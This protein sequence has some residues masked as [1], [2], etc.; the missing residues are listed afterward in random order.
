LDVASLSLRH[1]VLFASLLCL[2][3]G[4]YYE[5]FT[6]EQVA[7]QSASLPFFIGEGRQLEAVLNA[8]LGSYLSLHL[9][10]LNS[11]IQY[12]AVFFE[13]EFDYKLP[14]TD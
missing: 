3:A 6:Q 8:F 1:Q 13:T 7:D 12:C 14:S 2:L 5:L 9:S 4:I 10:E 11:T